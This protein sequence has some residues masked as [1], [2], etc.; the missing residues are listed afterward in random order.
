MIIIKIQW[1][2]FPRTVISIKVIKEEK[3]FKFIVGVYLHL[4]E[5][6]KARIVT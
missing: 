2:V 6:I 3:V 5:T 4:D 1:K